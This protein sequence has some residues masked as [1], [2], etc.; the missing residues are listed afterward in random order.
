MKS[1]DFARCLTGFLTDYLPAQQ[2]F[3]PNTIKAYRDVFVIFLRY[4]RD[5][6]GWT[7]EK[8][9]LQQ[10]NSSV[11]VDFLQFL[12]KERK[13]CKRTRNH[14]LA[15]LHSFFR[16]VQTEMPDYILHCQR[17]LAIPFH[18]HERPALRYLETDEL[19]LILSQPDL[20]KPSGRRD[21]VLLSLLYDSGARVQELIDLRARDIRLD[22]PPHVCLTGKGRKSRIVP[23]MSNTAEFLSEYIIERDQL[24]PG[25]GDAPLFTNRFG[26]KLSRSGIRYI[27]LKYV[28]QAKATSPNLNERVS[29]HTF[30]HTK[31]MHLLIAGNPPVI[32]RD[33]LGHVDINSTEVYARANLEM[34]RKALEKAEN[35]SSKPIKLTP[36]W[37]NDKKLLG[38]LQSL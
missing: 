15:A 28:R 24:S 13:C 26:D 11:I 37:Q 27:L 14:R 33:F 19:G 2:N 7:P 23:L 3:S 5:K 16:Y 34:K 22:P 17:I 12:I 21:A 6:R 35:L 29:P 38:W 18:R 25:H 36:M 1:T 32:I 10:I 4:C 9:R 8:I 20:K 31:A 30:R